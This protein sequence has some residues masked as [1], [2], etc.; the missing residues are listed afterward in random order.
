MRKESPLR[1]LLTVLVTAVVCSF[2]V[3][4]SVVLLRP[5]QLNNKLLERSVDVMSLTGLLPADG[6]VGEERL[7]DLF[8]GLDA[9]VVNIDAA[10]LDSEFDP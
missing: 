8:K 6:D 7:L 4:A 1:A 3:S 9:R 10:T 5:I 2:F